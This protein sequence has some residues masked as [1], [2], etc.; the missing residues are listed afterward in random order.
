MARPYRLQGEN[1]FYHIT[2][3]GDGRRKIYGSE[4]DYNKFLEYLLKAKERYQFRFYAYALM[5]NHFHLLIETLKP[6]IS[7][8]MHYIK[9]S[10][11][12]Y[13]NTKRKNVGHLFQGRFKSIVVDQDNYFLLLTRYIH[14]NPVRKIRGQVSTLD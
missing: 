13:Y 9:S 5:P 12:T 11:T 10:Y 1:I 6:N 4:S 2:S 7:Q 3:R 14:L 8:I